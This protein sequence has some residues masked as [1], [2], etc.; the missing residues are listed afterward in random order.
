MI[1]SLKKQHFPI[2]LPVVNLLSPSVFEAMAARRMRRRFVAAAV[3][4]ALLV[5]SGWGFQHLR[6]VQA[7][8][9]LTVEQA[10]TSRLTADTKELAPVSAFVAEVAKQKT[11]VK[12]A[13][14]NEALTSRVLDDLRAA[15][16]TGVRIETANATID[17]AQPAG[18]AGQTSTPANVCPA[19]NP[20]VRQGAVG[21]V[22]LTGTATSRAVV[23]Q[24]V[25][26]LGAGGV[27]V[28]PY[29]TTTSTADGKRVTFSGSVSVSKRV[30]SNRYAD[31]DAL[32]AAAGGR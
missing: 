26:K 28:A 22:T 5:G 27:F 23:G 31:I 2:G 17:G 18:K 13:M 21:C 19:P 6:S 16:P 7:G 30:Y 1:N 8:K 4:L 10:E 20:F 11:T 3:V 29:V 12:K 24:F 9:L 15:T 14:A 32:L 25:I